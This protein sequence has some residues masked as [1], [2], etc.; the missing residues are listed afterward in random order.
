MPTIR[1]GNCLLVPEAALEKLRVSELT[2]PVVI[3]RF[4]SSRRKDVI[5][6]TLRTFKGHAS[7]ICGSMFTNSGRE[8]SIV[9]PPR[10][11]ERSPHPNYK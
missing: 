6:T 1:I 11:F 2:Y 4:F 8:R 3:D 5:T 10:M 9:Q 7:L